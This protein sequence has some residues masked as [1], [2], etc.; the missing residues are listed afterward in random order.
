M[1]RVQC[2]ERQYWITYILKRHEWNEHQNDMKR[3]ETDEMTRNEMNW[4]E[5]HEQNELKMKWNDMTWMKSNAMYWP[6]IN[7][8]AQ[9]M[10]KAVSAA[11]PRTAG[12][13]A[14][15]LSQN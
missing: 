14:S 1:A 10:Q 4:C 8:Q 13:F 15:Y 12:E 9:W 2:H 7:G 6:D 5:R 3:N 11:L